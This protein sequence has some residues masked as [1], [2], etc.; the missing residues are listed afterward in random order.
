MLR[1]TNETAPCPSADDLNAETLWQQIEPYRG[2]TSKWYPM[3]L[4]ANDE[5]FDQV[6]NLADDTTTCS[7]LQLHDSF[8]NDW[9]EYLSR[10]NAKFQELIMTNKVTTSSAML[11]KIMFMLR[12][13]DDEHRPAGFIL[14]CAFI[15]A[16]DSQLQQQA[17]GVR[18]VSCYFTLF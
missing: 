18:E 11:A 7:F 13:K 12:W 14:S 10:L 8:K 2:S 1:C 4:S 3:L 6:F 5:A 16:L 17:N 15:L 9:M